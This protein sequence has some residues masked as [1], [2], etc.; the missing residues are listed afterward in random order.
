MRNEFILRTTIKFFLQNT[1]V[2]DVHRLAEIMNKTNPP[3]NRPNDP[4]I[5]PYNSVL[6]IAS[7]NCEK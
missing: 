7:E 4:A 5:V 3:K 1:S 6:E 2:L